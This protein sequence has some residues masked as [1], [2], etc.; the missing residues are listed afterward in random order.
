M[1]DTPYSSATARAAFDPGALWPVVDTDAH[2]GPQV[3]TSVMCWRH[4]LRHTQRGFDAGFLWRDCGE[5]NAVMMSG[6]RGRALH[7][8]LSCTVPDF[9]VWVSGGGG[10]LQRCNSLLWSGGCDSEHMLDLSPPDSPWLFCRAHL[11]RQEVVFSCVASEKEMQCC[12]RHQ[13]RSLWMEE[14]AL[15]STA[16]QCFVWGQHSSGRF[17]NL[18]HQIVILL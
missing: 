16:S 9:S 8:R 13:R 5:V 15:G 10:L 14:C 11:P 18:F 3:Q 6:G 1:A 2:Q 17:V 12:F 7:V 4:L